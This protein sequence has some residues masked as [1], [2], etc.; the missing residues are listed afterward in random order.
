MGALM[1]SG[2]LVLWLDVVDSENCSCP[3]SRKPVQ[4]RFLPQEGGS[5]S[6]EGVFAKKFSGSEDSAVDACVRLQSRACAEA[7]KEPS[8]SLESRAAVPVRILLGRG[9]IR[10]RT[11]RYGLLCRSAVRY[12]WKVCQ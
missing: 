9:S 5:L 10:N 3:L 8:A 1:G 4:K 2:A 6:V 11:Q 7:F 12:I